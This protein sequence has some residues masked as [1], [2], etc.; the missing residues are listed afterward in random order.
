[1]VVIRMRNP[2]KPDRHQAFLLPACQ[3]SANSRSK[4]Y[5][6]QLN[7]KPNKIISALASKNESNQKNEGSL[8]YQFGLFNI[9]DTFVF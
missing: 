8:L 1:M 6:S 5:C 9:V 7:Q 3:R 2:R 4:F